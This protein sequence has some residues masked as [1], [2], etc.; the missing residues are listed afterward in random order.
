MKLILREY[1]AS[2]R[3]RE[4]LDAILPDLLSELGFS[5]YSRPRRGTTQHGVDIAA[6]SP[7]SLGEQKVYLLSIKKGDLTRQDWDGTPQALRSS[8]GEIL[9]AYIGSRIPPEYGSLK[10]VICLCFGGDMQEQVRPLVNGFTEKNTTDRISFEEWNGDKIAGLLLGGVLREDLLPKA[11][12]SHFQK[13]VALLDE[14]DIAY[15]HFSLLIKRLLASVPTDDGAARIRAARQIY[16][17]VWIMFVWARDIGNVEAPYQ[18]SELAILSVWELMKP[19]LDKKTREREDLKRVLAQLIEVHLGISSELIEK[20]VSPHVHVRDGLA[21]AVHSRSHIDVNLKL[22]DLIGRIAMMG[23]WLQWS[24][25][26][27]E[28]K[29]RSTIREAATKLCNAGLSM[30]ENNAT[31]LLPVTDKQATHIALFLMLCIRCDVNS[32]R[33]L[34]WLKAMIDRYGFT[35]LTQNHYPTSSDDYRN[36]INH[37]RARSQE[38]FEEATAGSTLIPLLAAWVTGFQCPDLLAQL[39]KLTA[40]KLGHCNMQLWTVAQDSEEHLYLN[41]A[42]HGRAISD[43]VVIEDGHALNNAIDEACKLD[44]AFDQLSAVKAGFEPII[45]LACRHWDLPIPPDFWIEPLRLS[46]EQPTAN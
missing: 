46:D 8:L 22:F 26:R 38:Y 5:V 7:A 28:E 16:I 27:Q 18:A 31:L 3:E 2:L 43:L 1:L 11:L 25:P 39:A 44:G 9:D 4:E 6:V 15:R 10:I 29:M 13:S 45:L 19:L 30:I 41:S 32:D 24:I 14:P 20:K 35:I 42:T 17:C 36:L 23:L 21:T 33:V 12:K 34:A 40:E 37:P